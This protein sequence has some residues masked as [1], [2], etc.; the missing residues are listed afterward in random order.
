MH[1]KE[2]EHRK[3]HG[4]GALPAQQARLRSVVRSLLTPL[5]KPERPGLDLVPTNEALRRCLAGKDVRQDR[6]FLHAE[7]LAKTGIA[8]STGS[9]SSP[10]CSP[11]ANG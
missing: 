3:F 4:P 6:R 8:S 10:T 1:R 5:R 7:E 11:M 2:E 9:W